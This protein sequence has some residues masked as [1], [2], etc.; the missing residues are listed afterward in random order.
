MSSCA[1]MILFSLRSSTGWTSSVCWCV[2]RCKVLWVGSPLSRVWPLFS[3][4]VV[5]SR[6]G[7]SGACACPQRSD[8]FCVQLVTGCRVTCFSTSMSRVCVRKVK[9][10]RLKRIWFW[11]NPDLKFDLSSLCNHLEITSWVSGIVFSDPFFF[12]LWRIYWHFWL[13]TSSLNFRFSQ[14]TVW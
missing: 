13:L 11:D 9:M 2:Q 10:L 3:C 8:W 14:H 12:F 6:H 7:L 1:L 5:N 4:A